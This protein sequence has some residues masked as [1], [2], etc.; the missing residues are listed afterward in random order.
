MTEDLVDETII[1]QV[2]ILVQNTTCY[3]IESDVYDEASALL[4]W[5]DRAIA[6]RRLS[7]VPHDPPRQQTLKMIQAGAESQRDRDKERSVSTYQIE[8]GS[9]LGKE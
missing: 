5:D 6:F 7:P 8:N 3:L 4:G 2:Y 1:E 9:R